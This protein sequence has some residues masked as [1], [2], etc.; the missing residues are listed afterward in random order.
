LE[1]YITG[2]EAEGRNLPITEIHP[3]R[4]WGDGKVENCMV[5][6]VDGGGGRALRLAKNGEEVHCGLAANVDFSKYF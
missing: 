2:L 1:R 3:H 4:W 6:A 5:E